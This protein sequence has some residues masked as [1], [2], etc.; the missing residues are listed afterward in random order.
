MG[1]RALV[2]V[3]QQ[4]RQ[5]HERQD[6]IK[7]HLRELGVDV[8]EAAR[9]ESETLAQLV[10]R[11]RQHVD[12]VIL[13]GGD[14]TLNAAVEGLVK[15]QLPLGILPLGTA[16]D[17]A[18][19]LKLPM[20]L[21][22]ACG[23]I[24]AGHTQR[25]DLG[26]V[27]GKHFFNV[28]SLGLSVAITRRLTKEHKKAWGVLA[29]LRTAMQMSY[30]ARPFRAEIRAEGEVYH[31]KSI[32]IAVGNGR[33]YGGGMTISENATIDDHHLD[34][35]S[36]EIDHWWQIIWLLPRLRSG[37]LSGSKF[38]RTIRSTSF[39]IVTKRKRRINTDGEITG[40]TPATFQVVPQALEVFVP[41][42]VQPQ[43]PQ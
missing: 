19:T 16:N 34:L 21:R 36:L 20:E 5:G 23:V 17:L 12:L 41:R 3:N 11:H 7:K 38:A 13:G 25:I 6:A 43:K 39:E 2:V 1:R 10:L 18:R 28:A 14:G 37:T 30:R 40:V 33:H 22:E 15:A 29:Y 26:Q 24:A 9:R 32:Q 35:Y 31:V 42:P 8:L 27:N 4:A